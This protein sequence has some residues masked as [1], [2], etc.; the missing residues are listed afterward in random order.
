MKHLT[1]T[2]QYLHPIVIALV[3]GYVGHTTGYKAGENNATLKTKI[4]FHQLGPTLE[5]AKAP[6][7]YSQEDTLRRAAIAYGYASCIA[8]VPFMDCMA[9][10]E[11]SLNIKPQ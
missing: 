4:A 6:A 11:V 2:L 7:H 10:M 9:D 5:Q 8:G 1:T 3:C